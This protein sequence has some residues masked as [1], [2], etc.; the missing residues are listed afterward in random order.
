MMEKKVSIVMSTYN[1]SGYIGK[2]IKSVLSQS[3]DNFEFIIIDDSSQDNTEE[4]VKGFDDGRIIYIKN[5]E[6]KGLLFNLNKGINLAQG[7]YIARIDSDDWWIDKE[8]LKKQVDFLDNNTDYALVGTWAKV[9]NEKVVE[10]FK[11]THDTDF[12]KIKQKI[13]L[14]NCF[15]HSSVLFRKSVANEC[16]NYNESQEYVEDYALWL[17]MGKKHKLANI[18]EY[19]TGYLLNQEGVTQKNN[20][21]QI[22]ANIILIKKYKKEYPNYILGVLKWRVK[23]FLV[24]LKLSRLINYLKIS[25]R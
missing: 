13:L 15:V 2:A 25:K 17:K 10:L 23:G 7:E 8:K 9:Y 21:K 5:E 16:G 19:S 14:K 4:I 12:E 22:R 20:L 3:Y 11:I 6:N 24:F 1:D 18:P